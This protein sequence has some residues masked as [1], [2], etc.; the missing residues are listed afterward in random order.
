MTIYIIGELEILSIIKIIMRS[1]NTLL[2]LYIYKNNL[3]TNFV[4]FRL[5]GLGLNIMNKDNFYSE[6]IDKLKCVKMFDL[7]RKSELG[8]WLETNITKNK[9]F[10]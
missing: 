10:H 8:Q 1:M 9:Y 6:V 4:I 5:D 2:P 7:T 3:P